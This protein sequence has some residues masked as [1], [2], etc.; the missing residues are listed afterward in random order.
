[1]DVM[2][3]RVAGLDVHK[4]TV[5]ACVLTGPPLGPVTRALRVF[6]TT[7]RALLDLQEWLDEHAVTDVVMEATGIYWRPVFN[8]LQHESATV[9][10][11]TGLKLIL[12][13]PQHVKN[14]PGRKTDLRDA[15]WLAQLARHGLERASF[16][17]ARPVRELRDLARYRKKL[18]GQLSAEKNRAQKVLEELGSP[19]CEST[20]M[21]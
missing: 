13:N 9:E 7:T 4:D 17:P 12:A 1:M 16:V 21:R 19:I 2:V 20:R 14:V 5:V 6:G 8:V 15:E 10:E 18:V 11:P 3:E